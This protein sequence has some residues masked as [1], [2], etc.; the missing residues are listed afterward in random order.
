MYKYFPTYRIHLFRTV[1]AKNIHCFPTRHWNRFLCIRN[2]VFSMTQKPS[3]FYY[4]FKWTLGLIFEEINNRPIGLISS[5]ALRALNKLP[6]TNTYL[7]LRSTI[8]SVLFFNVFLCSYQKKFPHYTSINYR[9]CCV[10]KINY[11]LTSNSC[12]VASA[13]YSVYIQSKN[14]CY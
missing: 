1:V 12:N 8:M 7:I 13:N 10:S 9:R 3:S 2:G 11:L 4:Q 5:S 14:G 6:N